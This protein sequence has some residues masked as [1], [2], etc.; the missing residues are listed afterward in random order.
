MKFKYKIIDRESNLLTDEMEAENLQAA[1]EKLHH[2]GYRIVSLEQ[3]GGKIQLIKPRS[4]IPKG[5]LALLFSQLALMSSG[6]LDLVTVMELMARESKGLRKKKLDF[7]VES[8]RQGKLL[9]EAF[10]E[11]DC[12]PQFVPGMIKSGES[13]GTLGD[14]FHQL[15]VFFD[16]EQQMHRKLANALAYPI[17][18][19]ITSLF[20][21]QVVLHS[22]LPVFTDVFE[23]QQVPLPL[24]TR[25]LM[26]IADHVNRFG[27]IYLAALLIL[28]LVILLLK[29]HPKT[30]EGFYRRWY[31]L[32][33]GA[34]FYRDPFELRQLRTMKMQM[35][36]GV[37]LLRIM[38]N[39][40]E[41][42]ENPYI[43]R[44]ASEMIQGLM[45]GEALS[46]AMEESELFKAQNCSFVALGEASSAVS[47]MLAVAIHL[48]E[49]RQKNRAE[50]ISIYME[51]ALILLMAI[52]VGF[53]IFSI[54]IPMF[55][56]VNSF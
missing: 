17:F 52:V 14:I 10:D 44:K 8:V 36:N 35:D 6:G 38:E 20:V 51:P 34:P 55:D 40:N 3:A 32:P 42:A 16:E 45:K 53:I 25:M 28:V 49:G 50:R 13:A 2:A 9:S 18:L 33:I 5:Q 54:A 12:F 24:M 29:N 39:L 56:M 30:A 31:H 27:M 21:L 26:A 47:E 37:D 43:K 22:V 19:M 1:R 23:S 48:E 7:I 11:A 41:G 46:A 4:T 15:A